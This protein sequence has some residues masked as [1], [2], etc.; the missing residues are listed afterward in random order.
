MNGRL[1]EIVFEPY[2][3]AA[4]EANRRIGGAARMAMVDV[5]Y[6]AGREM[7]AARIK[8]QH[9]TWSPEQIER[10]ITRRL[11]RDAE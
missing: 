10:E 8:G 5:L 6:R 9:P 4:V 7:M 3:A 1:R 11:S 2:D